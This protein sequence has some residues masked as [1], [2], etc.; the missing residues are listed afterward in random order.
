[1]ISA[2][3]PSDVLDYQRRML[4]SGAPAD[5]VDAAMRDVRLALDASQPDV[6]RNAMLRIAAGL[7]RLNESGVKVTAETITDEQIAASGAGE[8]DREY[9]VAV[10]PNWPG[11]KRWWSWRHREAK[12]ACAAA[13]NARHGDSK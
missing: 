8:E 6:Q 9:A 7:N 4:A 10:D 1:M 3:T 2:M 11:G 13:W 5:V 12:R